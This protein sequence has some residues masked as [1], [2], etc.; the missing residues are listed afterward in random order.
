M[1]PMPSAMTTPI[2]I[3]TGAISLQNSAL[4][5]RQDDAEHEH[6]RSQS[7]RELT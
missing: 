5:H 1:M 2:P 3:Q 4:P 6:D 7:G